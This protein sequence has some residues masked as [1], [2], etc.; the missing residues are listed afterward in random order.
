MIPNPGLAAPPAEGLSSRPARP[1]LL[2]FTEVLRLEPLGEGVY[3]GRTHAGRP[4]RAFGGVTL[5]QALLSAGRTVDP[6]RGVHSLHA[7]FLRSPDP[8]GPAVEYAVDKLRDGSSYAAR[9]V[10]ARQGDRTVLSLSAS[11]KLPERGHDRQAE[12]PSAPDPEDLPDVYQALAV[13][14][15]EAY[16]RMTI[17]RVLD[18]RAVPPDGPELDARGDLRSRQRAWFRS[19]QPMPDD[20]RLHAAVLA[21]FSDLT[22]SPTA[23]LPWEPGVGQRPRGTGVVLASLDHAMWFHRPVRAD[24]W[25]LYSQQTTTLSDGRALGR[26]ELWTRDGRLV[27]TVVQEALLRHRAS[28]G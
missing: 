16:A 6:D 25:L 12:P 4:P 22:I 1:D 17:P 27:A 10:T 24:D 8:E 19:A 5:S 21:Y 7:Y 13:E 26:G 2:E 14:R 15:P 18:L 20:P 28:E 23:A 11:F 9:Q 3:Q